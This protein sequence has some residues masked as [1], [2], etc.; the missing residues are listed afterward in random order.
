M[1]SCRQSRRLLECIKDHFL[2]QVIDSP[3]RGDA[4]LD[5]LVT[6]VSEL[7]SESEIGGILDCSDHALM[8]FA[9]LRDMGQA[10]SKF[11]TLNFRKVKFQLLK[12]LVNRTF[13]QTALRDK[14]A[15]QSWRIFKDVFH[16]VQ[17]LLIPRCKKSEKKGK[18][19]A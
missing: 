6:N 14:G 2:S 12:E 7:N 9:I 1:V 8:E 18:R 3:T 4:L 10:K 16:R 15:E 13:W 17:E 19:L 11:R 5:L